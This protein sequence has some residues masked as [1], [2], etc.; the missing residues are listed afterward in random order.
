MEG[1]KLLMNSTKIG[2][3]IAEFRATHLQRL[4]NKHTA[5]VGYR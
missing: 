5:I 3:L 4:N 2:N 1:S